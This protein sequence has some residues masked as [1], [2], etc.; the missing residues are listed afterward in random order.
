MPLYSTRP[1]PDGRCEIICTI[2]T[3]SPDEAQALCA[4]LNA[5]ANEGCE[6]GVRALGEVLELARLTSGRKVSV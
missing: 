5:S 4:A 6:A 3:A 2:A 1:L